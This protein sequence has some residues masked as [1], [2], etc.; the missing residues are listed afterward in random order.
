MNHESFGNV[1]VNEALTQEGFT[2]LKFFTTGH[3]GN[4]VVLAENTKHDRYVVKI[5][6]DEISQTEVITNLQGYKKIEQNGISDILPEVRR[7]GRVRQFTY[8]VTNFL[9]DDFATRAHYE[10]VPELMYTKLAHNMEPIYGKTIQVDGSSH[11]FIVRIQ[12]LLRKNYLTHILRAKLIDPNTILPHLAFDIDAFNT[13]KSCF[14]VF[15]FTPEDV[16]LTENTIK[17]PDPKADI[18]GNPI[19]DLACFA[20]I[21]RDVYALP[22]SSHGYGYLEDLAI[23][24]VSDKLG[25]TQ[26]TARRLFSL[27]RSLQYSL[28]ARFRIQ[29]DPTI[30]QEYAQESVRYLRDA[31]RHA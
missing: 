3:S 11:N 31:I 8:L 7:T 25:L 1:L 6:Q 30:A 13:P 16:Y 5:P 2:F 4:Q 14:A 19:I 20:G 9:G 15:D 26:S 10:S 27:G 22:G 28:S 12:E 21:S 17:Y 18:R 29:S 24:D 23:Y